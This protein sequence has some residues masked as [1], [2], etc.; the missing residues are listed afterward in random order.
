M[1]ILIEKLNKALE[2][3]NLNCVIKKETNTIVHCYLYD[4]NDYTKMGVI[5]DYRNCKKFDTKYK[6]DDLVKIIANN[7]LSS[8]AKSERKAYDMADKLNLLRR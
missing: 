3:H 1:N 5:Y 8:F 7:Q 2:K 4:I 6:K